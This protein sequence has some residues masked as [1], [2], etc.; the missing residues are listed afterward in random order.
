MNYLV[1][2]SF[3][4]GVSS[5]IM[6]N[7]EISDFGK[8]VLPRYLWRCITGRSC[9]WEYTTGVFSETLFHILHLRCLIADLAVFCGTFCL[10][11]V[12]RVYWYFWRNAPRRFEL[13]KFFS[14]SKILIFFARTRVYFVVLCDF[15]CTARVCALLGMRF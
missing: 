8:H 4:S 2:V 12:K 6:W 3:K 9:L 13:E 1:F 14:L 7:F 15:L 5:V 10:N 11:L